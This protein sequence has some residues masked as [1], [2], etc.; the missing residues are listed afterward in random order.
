MGGPAAA[1][2]RPIVTEVLRERIGGG[3]PAWL[4]VRGRSMRP[5]LAR[6]TRVLVAPATRVRPGDLLAYE[7]EGAIVCHRVLG[8]RGHVLL[9]R[10]DHRGAGPERV[11]PAQVVGVVVALERDG[12]VVDLTAPR[13]RAL[14]IVAAARSLAAAAWAAARRRA[15]RRP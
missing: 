10:A 4:P 7:C 12:A 2:W 11:T 6:G 14:A 9:T 1:V 5:L 15:W 13:R 3:E 8:R